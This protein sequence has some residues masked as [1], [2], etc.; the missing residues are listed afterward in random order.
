MF[1]QDAITITV[2]VDPSMDEIVLSNDSDIEWTILGSRI[3]YEHQEHVACANDLSKLTLQDSLGNTLSGLGVQIT[4]NDASLSDRCVASVDGV[5][6]LH[7]FS[8][9][10]GEDIH[11]NPSNP[12][13]LSESWFVQ[14]TY[15]PRPLSSGYGSDLYF[16]FLIFFLITF[17]LTWLFRTKRSN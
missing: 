6:A 10:S 2:D 3:W 15:I 11:T 13:G 9:A 7:A 16:G 4:S 8:L 17:F 14:L 5:Q 1:P 12:S